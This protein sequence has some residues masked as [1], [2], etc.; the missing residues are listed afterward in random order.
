[1]PACAFAQH[2]ASL[3]IKRSSVTEAIDAFDLSVTFYHSRCRE[4]IGIVSVLVPHWYQLIT[5]NWLAERWHTWSDTSF[6]LNKLHSHGFCM[7]V[8]LS[9]SI[10]VVWF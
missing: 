4:A 1:M 3:P 8:V 2:I 5:K 6:F 9:L 7:I 10:C